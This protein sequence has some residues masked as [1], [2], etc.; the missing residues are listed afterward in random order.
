[1]SAAKTT[2]P[3]GAVSISVSRSARGALLRAVA[4]GVGDDQ[5]R[6]GGE[7]DEGSPHPPG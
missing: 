2:T 6:L 4:P 5:G 1:M 7:Q 3:T